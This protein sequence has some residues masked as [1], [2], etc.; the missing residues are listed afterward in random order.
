MALPAAGVVLAFIARVGGPLAIKKAIKKF[1][2]KAVLKATDKMTY[3]GKNIA[4][5]SKSYKDTK[6]AKETDK[7]RSKLNLPKQSP[8]FYRR[9]EKGGSV[10]KYAGGSKVRKPRSY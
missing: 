7:I 8:D 3:I 10:K 5:K 4:N 9:L 2:K 6:I 1:G